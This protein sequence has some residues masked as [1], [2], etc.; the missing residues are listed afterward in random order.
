MSYCFEN[1]VNI[2][3]TEKTRKEISKIFK[4]MP[5]DLYTADAVTDIIMIP[6]FSLLLDGAVLTKDNR[7]IN[8]LECYFTEWKGNMKKCLRCRNHRDCLEATSLEEDIDI[9][10]E[11]KVPVILLHANKKQREVEDLVALIPPMP[12]N[13]PFS[14]ELEYWLK[15]TCLACQNKALRWLKKNDQWAAIE[16]QKDS[17][18]QKTCSEIAAERWMPKNIKVKLTLPEFKEK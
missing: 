4:K 15:S 18:K 14:L 1:T 8:L 12:V 3:A 13:E 17:N 10:P 16:H 11:Y 7:H 2:W 6:C 5:F 9:G